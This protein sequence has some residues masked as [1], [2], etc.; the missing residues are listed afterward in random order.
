MKPGFP[1]SPRVGRTVDAMQVCEVWEDWSEIFR[2]C[3]SRPFM[4]T[5]IYEE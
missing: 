3:I 2:I 4:G 1:T 5:D